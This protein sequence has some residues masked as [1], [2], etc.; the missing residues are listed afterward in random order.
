MFSC[1]ALQANNKRNKCAFA[2]LASKI[3]NFF[4]NVV[5]LELTE[6]IFSSTLASNVTADF[7]VKYISQGE[8]I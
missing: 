4:M 1:Q 2:K 6:V 8:Y 5:V 7:Y 3:I